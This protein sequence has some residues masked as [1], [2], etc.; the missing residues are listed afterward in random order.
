[1]KL[2]FAFWIAFF[3]LGCGPGAG[4]GGGEVSEAQLEQDVLSQAAVC[5]ADIKQEYEKRIADQ[6][7]LIETAEQRVKLLERMKHYLKGCK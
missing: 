7:K 1:M 2:F 5:G 4:G 3:W 6:K